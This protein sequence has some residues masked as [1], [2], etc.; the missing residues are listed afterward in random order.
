MEF[1]NTFFFA[2][3][4]AEVAF[5]SLLSLSDIVFSARV[6]MDQPEHP[7]GSFV[8]ATVLMMKRSGGEFGL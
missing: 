7:T 8:C 5:A 1:R 4:F 3:R 6:L 2:E